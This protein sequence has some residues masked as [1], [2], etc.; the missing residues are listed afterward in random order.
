MMMMMMMMMMMRRRR[1]R[2]RDRSFDGSKDIKSDVVVIAVKFRVML[3][4]ALHLLALVVDGLASGGL[5]RNRSL[6]GGA[7]VFFM[8]PNI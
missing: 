7:H 1:R 2:R 5:L 8:P 6:H 4:P 3:H